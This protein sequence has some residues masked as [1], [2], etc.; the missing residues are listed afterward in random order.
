MAENTVLRTPEGD[1]AVPFYNTSSFEGASPKAGMVTIAQETDY[2]F[3]DMVK[4]T[5]RPERPATF[6]VRL[7]VPG[8]AGRRASG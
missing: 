1:F 6:S 2:P 3:S 8:G 5:V 4:I 7:R